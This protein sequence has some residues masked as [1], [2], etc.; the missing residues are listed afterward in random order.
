MKKILFITGPMGGHGGEETV[1]KQVIPKLMDKYHVELLVSSQIGEQEWTT[2][3][4]TGLTKLTILNN[5]ISSV[6]KFARI[7]SISRSSKADIIIALSPRMLEIAYLSQ[8]FKKNP[9]KLVSWL[10]FS[11]TD[12]YSKRTLKLLKHADD[13]FVLTKASKKQLLNENIGIQQERIFVTYNPVMMQKKYVHRSSDSAPTKFICVS[14]IQ[15]GDQKNLQELFKACAMLSG[16][17][18]LSIYGNDDSAN[19]IET[20]KCKEYIEQL[21]IQSH[22][23]W[24]GFFQNVWQQIHTADCLVLTSRY[25]GLPMVLCE[26]ISY[27]V[28]VVSS[29]CPTGPAEIVNQQNGFLYKM[30]DVKNLAMYLQGFIAKNYHFKQADVVNSIEN[31][32]MDRYL[33]HFE[34]RIDKIL[35]RR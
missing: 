24:K 3:F 18:Q 29:D 17:W 7:F 9:A 20:K 28:P 14:R 22:I 1:L 31:F 13:N 34:N 25:E 32:Y 19:E 8:Q 16:N 30:G 35:S 12:K 23:V 15:F 11:L 26:S 6:K 27:G 10:H 2:D 21:G 5:K 4:E 33:F